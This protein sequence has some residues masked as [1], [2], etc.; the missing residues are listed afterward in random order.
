MTRNRAIRPVP[1]GVPGFWT[2][3]RRPKLDHGALERDLGKRSDEVAAIERQLEVL[4]RDVERVASLELQITSAGGSEVDQQQR[5]V[6]RRQSQLGLFRDL[7]ANRAALVEKA[8]TTADAQLEHATKAGCRTGD[9]PGIRAEQAGARVASQA[10]MMA[11]VEPDLVDA[12]ATHDADAAQLEA[13][14][15]DCDEQ[16]SLTSRRREDVLLSSRSSRSTRLSRRLDAARAALAKLGQAQ[17]S[18][19]SNHVD[20]STLRAI[21]ASDLGLRTVRAQLEGSRPTIRAVAH[22]PVSM[23]IDGAQID[24]PTGEAL[25]MSFAEIAQ[26]EVPHHLELRVSA[27]AADPRLLEKVREAEAA[28]TEA[29]RAA[30]VAE[31]ATAE[32]AAAERRRVEVDAQLAERSLSEALGSSTLEELST[33]IATLEARVTAYAAKRPP[34]PALTEELTEA[35]RHAIDAESRAVRSAR[36]RQRPSSS[37]PRLASSWPRLLRHSTTRRQ[38]CPSSRR[39][40]SVCAAGSV[41]P[42]RTLPTMR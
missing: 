20:E 4:Q 26:V 3:T 37:H 15:R 17:Q 9:R 22:K 31:L 23:Q 21:R 11:A 24:L 34:E 25:E 14:R 27:G 30:G 16:E 41:Q 2:E 28:L 32:L 12:K 39:T 8:D 38:F 19:G 18:L 29:C 13:A 1:R 42:E 33:T 6:T 35:D 7:E 40:W 5:R 36:L 10:E